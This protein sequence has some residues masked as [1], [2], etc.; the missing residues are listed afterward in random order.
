[1]TP[2]S[3]TG[4]TR[5]RFHGAI[6]GVGT[7]SGVRVVVGRWEE[8]PWG[9]FA[10]VM[11]A[12]PDGTRV[13]LAPD[14]RVAEFVSSTY[15]FDRVQIGPVE[16]GV[17]DGRWEVAAPDL[18][19]VIGT[20]RRPVLG[21]LLRAVPSGLATA[22]AWA[23]LTDPIARLVLRGVRTRGS[24]GNGRREYYGATD[25]HLVTEA[26]GTWQGTDLGALAAV[27]PDPLFGFG[28]TPTR[29]SVTSLVTTVDL[30]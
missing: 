15:T 9:S 25:L 29:P 10:D 5:Q 13:L 27:V 28:S 16:V 18:E 2:S 22:P 12:E 21:W 8:S 17:R 30:R 11:L 26:R 14:E 7:T 4:A 6:A 20:G 1:M 19:L 3:G 23:R 24:A